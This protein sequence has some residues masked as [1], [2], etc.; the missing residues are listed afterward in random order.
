MVISY[1]DIIMNLC[2]KRNEH[3]LDEKGYK[4]LNKLN[5]WMHNDKEY[6]RNTIIP[7]M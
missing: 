3:A 1:I 6:L 7:N 2:D 4:Q 5:E